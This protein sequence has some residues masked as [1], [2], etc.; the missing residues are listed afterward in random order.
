M[1]WYW[2]NTGRR[3]PQG[4]HVL[5]PAFALEPTSVG[6]RSSVQL[7]NGSVTRLKLVETE[8]EMG[9]MWLI[10]GERSE[11]HPISAPH[12]NEDPA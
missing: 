10:P 3:D 11:H 6:S 7:P 2:S 1:A 8:P 12:P 5:I 4:G 9:E